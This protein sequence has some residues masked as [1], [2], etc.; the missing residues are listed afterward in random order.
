MKHGTRFLG[1]S[2]RCGSTGEKLVILVWAV[3]VSSEPGPR[4]VG[5][6]DELI[7]GLH[8]IF[9]LDVKNH[10]LCYFPCFFSFSNVFFS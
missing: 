9:I 10:H 6:V 8:T 7:V 1:K 5:E 2:P 3:L 4:W